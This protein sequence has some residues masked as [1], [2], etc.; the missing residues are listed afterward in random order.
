MSNEHLERYIVVNFEDCC[1]QAI[2]LP[3]G[4]VHP[5]LVVQSSVALI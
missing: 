1:I 5:P 3:H 2:V 4:W